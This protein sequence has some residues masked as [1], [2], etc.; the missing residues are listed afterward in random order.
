M[1]LLMVLSVISLIIGLAMLTNAT[2]GVGVIAVSCLFAIFA[3]IAQ[4]SSHHEELMKS[5]KVEETA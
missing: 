4:A 1:F 3:R 5:L 2:I